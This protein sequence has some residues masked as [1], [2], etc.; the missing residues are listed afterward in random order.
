MNLWKR[1]STK[2]SSAS[3]ASDG[4]CSGRDASGQ[5]VGSAIG[6]EQRASAFSDGI[7]SNVEHSIVFVSGGTAGA[8][9][10]LT[11]ASAI[12][13]SV[14]RVQVAVMVAVALSAPVS[15][16]PFRVAP[17][18]VSVSTAQVVAPVAVH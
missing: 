2:R 3:V 11:I 1:S 6:A 13:L 16:L 9:P 14:P 4:F 5:A 7:P 15:W 10:T 8:G 18:G 17:T 12:A